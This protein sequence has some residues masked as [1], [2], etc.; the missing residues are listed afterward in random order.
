MILLRKSIKFHAG[1]WIVCAPRLLAKKWKSFK[2]E[3]QV[4]E[5]LHVT[6]LGIQCS[7]YMYIPETHVLLHIHVHILNI[8]T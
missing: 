4:E 6:L 7:P 2:G 1:L 8:R 3:H 5:R